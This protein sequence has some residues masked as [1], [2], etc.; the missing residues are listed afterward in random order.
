MGKGRKRRFNRCMNCGSKESL[1][2]YGVRKAGHL[3]NY[4]YECKVCGWKGRFVVSKGHSFW[5]AV[6]DINTVNKGQCGENC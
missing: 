6:K 2:S 4:Y 3:I 1:N 5:V